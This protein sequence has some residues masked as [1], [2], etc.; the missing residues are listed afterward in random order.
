MTTPKPSTIRLHSMDAV[1]AIAMLLGIVLHASIAYKLS[2]RTSWP[3]DDAIHSL[4]YN[5]LY[6]LIHAFRMQLF[7]LVAGFFTRFL[8]LKIGKHN[9]IKHRLKRIAL[10]FL[11]GL[12]IIAPITM[13]PFIYYQYWLSNPQAHFLTSLPE[14][15][16]YIVRWNGMADLWFLYYLLIYYTL[17]LSL[18]SIKYINK[19]IKKSANWLAQNVLNFPKK[20]SF[21]LIISCIIIILF[22]FKEL[23]IRS[24]TGITPNIPLIIYYGLFYYLGYFIHH[25]YL[26]KLQ[27][28]SK[29]IILYIVLGISITPLL[30]HLYQ[31]QSPKESTILYLSVR[32]LFAFQTVL[33]VFGFL[34]AALKYLNTENHAFRYISDASYWMYLVHLPLV[35]GT[36]L[37]LI[38]SPVPPQLRFWIVNLIGIGIPLITYAL[39]IR[40][41]VIGTILNGPRKRR[42][43]Q[44]K[45][46]I[47]YGLA[48]VLPDKKNIPLQK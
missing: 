1:R 47:R 25:Y 33:L 21:L 34:G 31:I 9:F 16:K 43:P 48:S 29:N 8:Y 27:L 38:G 46:S 44:N 39:F 30:D 7:F 26:N 23:P 41:T 18:L 45:V 28:F 32:I 36:Q 24:Y 13:L 40:Y 12:I 42:S 20:S 2:P 19:F 15:V 37:W 10:P 14:I 11:F 5:Y 6:S 17:T 4:S 3:T 35:A 22:L